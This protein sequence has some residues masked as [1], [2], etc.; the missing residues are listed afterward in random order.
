MSGESHLRGKPYHISALYV[1]DLEKF[2][3]DRVGDTLRSQ[4]Q[5]SYFC[6]RCFNLQTYHNLHYLIH[7]CCCC[8]FVPTQNQP[9]IARH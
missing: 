4:Y 5:V 6:L 3:K 8:R 2:R 1:V 7:C 9:K